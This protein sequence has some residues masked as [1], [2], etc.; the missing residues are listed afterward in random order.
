MTRLPLPLA[1]KS[2]LVGLLAAM[3]LAGCI[4][5]SP[6]PA[7]S[8]SVSPASESTATPSDGESPRPLGSQPDARTEATCDDLVPP[9]S[10]D[11][12]YT[13]PIAL[14]DE[15][16]TGEAIGTVIAADWV[17]RE[18]GGV[19]CEWQDAESFVT[20]EGYF[21]YQGV[22]LLLLPATDA[23]S[24]A[25]FAEAG[26]GRRFAECTANFYC[27]LEARTDRGWWMSLT[28]FYFPTENPG[29]AALDAL[30]QI[31]GRVA[32][33][34]A[35]SRFG[36]PLSGDGIDSLCDR[37]ISPEQA[38]AALGAAVATVETSTYPSIWKTAEQIVG[39]SECRWY[40][41]ELRDATVTILPGGEWAMDR[42]V[43]AYGPAEQVPLPGTSSGGF[44]RPQV[45]AQGFDFAIDGDW[46]QVVVSQ[47]SAVPPRDVLIAYAEAIIANATD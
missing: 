30:E 14:V 18:A 41:G 16:R 23:Q 19:A 24:D 10:L 9:G 27:H 20:S 3:L 12:L 38:A 1:T 32:D 43:A 13:A 11:T 21:S 44:L 39:G 33:L 37:Q 46:V 47:G 7:P 35:P 8:G 40:G 29:T 28:A 45:E 36:G 5:A 15:T 2:A 6:T 25:Y 26:G 34:P 22:R 4:P 31:L 17:I 42:A